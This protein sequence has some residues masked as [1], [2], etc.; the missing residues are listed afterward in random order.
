MESKKTFITSE[1]RR[2]IQA[3]NYEQKREF[4]QEERYKEAVARLKGE[5]YEPQP[6]GGV[7]EEIALD[8]VRRGWKSGLAKAFEKKARKEGWAR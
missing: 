4:E 8:A 7:D 3:F 5:N 2:L 1:E 6:F